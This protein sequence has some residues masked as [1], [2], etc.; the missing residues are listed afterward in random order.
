MIRMLWNQNIVLLFE[1][2]E[3]NKFRIEQ[4]SIALGCILSICQPYI[5]RWPPVGVSTDGEGGRSSSEQVWTGFKWWPPD[6]SRVGP[7]PSLGH[8][9]MSAVGGP[10]P[11]DMGPGMPT[12]PLP[13]HWTW[14]THPSPEQNSFAGGKNVLF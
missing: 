7:H 12:P 14:D 11:L 1:L 9:Q 4:E 13:V 3:L 10:T 6:V 5:F 8:H 2:D